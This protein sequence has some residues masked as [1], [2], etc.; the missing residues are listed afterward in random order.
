LENGTGKPEGA[1][2]VREVISQTFIL[3]LPTSVNRLYLNY[4]KNGKKPLSAQY[5]AWVKEAGLNLMI[6]RF[7]P[8]VG[9]YELIIDA[10]RPDK[11]KRDLGNLEKAISDLLVRHGVVADDHYCEKITMAWVRED[12][13]GVR[14]T[15][16]GTPAPKRI[17]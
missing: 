10:V 13:V 2:P 1:D 3:P 12:F 4:T 6:Q 11:V 14:V 8:T 7:R 5:D 16:I 17:A 9:C 15:V